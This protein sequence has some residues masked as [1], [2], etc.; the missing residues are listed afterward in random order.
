MKAILLLAITLIALFSAGKLTAQEEEPVPL[1]TELQISPEQLTD[2]QQ[3]IYERLMST[4]IYE[5]A[6][7]V[8]IAPLEEA[9]ATG[10]INPGLSFLPSPTM[11]YAASDVQYEREGNYK[12]HGEGYG[13]DEEAPDGT[14]TLMNNDG[15][16]IGRINQ[17]TKDYAFF[18]LREGVQVILL[19]KMR[20]EQYARC[21]SNEP[22]GKPT[23]TTSEPCDV[24]KVVV[25]YMP[26]L[27]SYITD[28]NGMA[29]LAVYQTNLIW[30]NSGMFIHL[31][32]A[33]VQALNFSQSGMSD[34]DDASEADINNFKLNGTAISVRNQLSAEI[35]V[36]LTEKG[37]GYA[38]PSQ[39][40]FYVPPTY[41]S[42][43]EL[44]GR[45]AQVGADFS[46]S[47]AI[48]H[49]RF[50]TSPIYAFA[51]EVNHLYGAGHSSDGIPPARGYIFQLNSGNPQTQRGTLMS[52]ESAPKIVMHL[53]NPSVNYFGLPTGTGTRNN[54]G[55]IDG[56]SSTTGTKSTVANFYQDPSQFSG[57][58]LVSPNNPGCG[59]GV[60]ATA[61]TSCG[62]GSLFFWSISPNGYSNWTALT[63]YG[64]GQQN[65][66][67]A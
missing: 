66:N 47:F 9:T 50:A 62:A 11:R 48:V 55:W 5:A 40:P 41:N 8:S 44:G 65:P 56:T 49:A 51:H 15:W 20:G 18:D 23:G 64:S 52:D 60:T 25:F 32:L 30:K 57:T 46:T 6:Y 1:F 2:S 16:Y 14:I 4:G 21:G 27:T 24:T 29:N 58:I 10:H 59:P 67:N 35:A 43:Y 37:W 54:K 7:F 53:S 22:N 17:G 45:A 19:E 61:H 3:L 38:S 26:V 31:K 28:I 42:N 12:W 36:L 13:G 34:A 33:G 63:G 39:N